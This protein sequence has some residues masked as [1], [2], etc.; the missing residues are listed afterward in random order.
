[1]NANLKPALPRPVDE[2]KEFRPA[3]FSR[4]SSAS[5]G[6]K[7]LLSAVL[8]AA[9]ALIWITFKPPITGTVAH[10]R[11]AISG[12]GHSPASPKRRVAA[13]RTRRGPHSARAQQTQLLKD[14]ESALRPFEVYLLDGDR[15]IR[16]DA[17]NRSVLLNTQTG[18]ATWVDS[19][20]AADNQR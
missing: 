11:K 12:L 20:A 6:P 10:I 1:M 9:L 7:L 16:V 5:V 2:W 14:G 15:Y 18:E 8:V 3:E 4:R 19:D 17:S 13:E